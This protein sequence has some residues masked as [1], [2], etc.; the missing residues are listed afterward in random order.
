MI[1]IRDCA[2]LQDPFWIS[3]AMGFGSVLCAFVIVLILLN[4]TANAAIAWNNRKMRGTV[5]RDVKL[6]KSDDG[7]GFTMTG[8]KITEVSSRLREMSSRLFVPNTLSPK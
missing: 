7:Y 3:I 5:A 8:G 2:S 1:I 6:F 4:V